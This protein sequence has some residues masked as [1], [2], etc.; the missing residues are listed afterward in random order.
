MMVFVVVTPNND[1]PHPT[2][3]SLVPSRNIAAVR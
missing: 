1:A 3:R 2:P